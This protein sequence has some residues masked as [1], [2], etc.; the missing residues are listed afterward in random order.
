MSFVAN[1]LAAMHR[2]KRWGL[3]ALLIYIPLSIFPHDLVQY[4]VNQIAI[5]YT[6]KRL[7]QGAA[8]LHIAIAAIFTLILLPR[9]LKHPMRGRVAAMWILTIALAVATWWSFM[10]NNSE[11]VHFPQ[12]FP[13][14][15]ML[16]VLTG[17][18]LEAIAL[19]TIIGGLDEAFQYIWVVAGQPVPYDFN[20][21][22]MDMI[23]AASGVVFALSLL[24]VARSVVRR[25]WRPG[26]LAFLAVYPVGFLLWLSGKMV[27]YEAPGAGP[28]W[29]SLS[30]Q[31]T[32][33]FWFKAFFGPRIF[34]ELSPLEGPLVL[35]S[36]LVLYA[37]LLGD[38]EVS[39]PA[40]VQAR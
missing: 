33:P 19:A 3:F 23:G 24:P 38:L 17:S 28:H 31:V 11:L 27:L 29:F 20:D 32:P 34:H 8:A 5:H 4:Y 40:E 30:R 6:H 18:P 37:L 21:I 2:N 22:F 10:A 25:W 1:T 16:L 14:G 39:S 7:Y 26:V 13:E 15:M 12:Y 9:L 36:G 35:L